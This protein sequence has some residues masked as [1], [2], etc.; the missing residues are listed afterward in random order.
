MSPVFSARA[1]YKSSHVNTK[2]CGLFD[3]IKTFICKKKNLFIPLN[4]FVVWWG[5]TLGH[6]KGGQNFKLKPS[7]CKLAADQKEIHRPYCCQFQFIRG[8]WHLLILI[9]MHNSQEVSLWV[10]T[11][12]ISKRCEVMSAINWMQGSMASVTCRRTEV[13]QKCTK[14][15]RETDRKEIS[16]KKNTL[17]S[18]TSTLRPSANQCQEQPW[19]SWYATISQLIGWCVQVCTLSSPAVWETKQMDLKCNQSQGGGV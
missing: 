6:M 19:A 4:V 10:H 11:A 18:T 3:W 17:G 7:T 1:W 14:S 15:E 9:T 5:Y 2:C 12:T 13:P 16:L 8:K